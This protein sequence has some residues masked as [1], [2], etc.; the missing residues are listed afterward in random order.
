MNKKDINNKARLTVR[1]DKKLNDR[2]E[3]EAINLGLTKNGYISMVLHKEF[4]QKE[5]E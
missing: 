4:K 5:M 2:I 1:I 3:D